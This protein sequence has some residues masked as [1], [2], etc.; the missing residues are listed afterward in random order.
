M[1]STNSPAPWKSTGNVGSMHFILTVALAIEKLVERFP[2]RGVIYLLITR[3]SLR[4]NNSIIQIS[5]IGNTYRAI[6]VLDCELIKKYGVGGFGLIFP[7]NW[8]LHESCKIE[9]YFIFVSICNHRL[10]W[11]F[12]LE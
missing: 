10:Q 2:D 5:D 3:K 11:S 12:I 9:E 1:V 6:R 8:T 4:N 7:K